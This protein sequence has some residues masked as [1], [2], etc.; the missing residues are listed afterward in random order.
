M[1]TQKILFQGITYDDVLLIPRFSDT[2][3]RNAKLITKLSRNIQLNIPVLSAAMDTITEADM[4]LQA[5]VV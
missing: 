4:A 3:P 1:A 5:K 2:L